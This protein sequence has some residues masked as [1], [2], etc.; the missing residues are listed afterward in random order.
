LHGSSPMER[1]VPAEGCDTGF[2][3]KGTPSHFLVDDG[4]CCCHSY[5]GVAVGYVAVNASGSAKAGS[6]GVV[7]SVGS[8]HALAG[9]RAGALVCALSDALGEAHCH[10]CFCNRAS[11]GP[12]GDSVPSP[13][14]RPVDCSHTDDGAA[15]T[16]MVPVWTPV[17]AAPH[18]RGCPV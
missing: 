9:S 11:T 17:R 18:D 7:K 5:S 10:D 6:A 2:Y 13:V 12:G 4:G 8:E 3:L 15:A 1:W 16:A 14:G